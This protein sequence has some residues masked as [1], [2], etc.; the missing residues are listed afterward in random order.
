MNF[1]THQLLNAEELKTLRTNLTNP[2]LFWEDGK[3]AGKQA[4]LVKKNLQL[5][6]KLK[7]QKILIFDHKKIFQDELIKVFRSPKDSWSYVY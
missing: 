1:L 2:N 7:F 3:T 5:V 4:S 6:E